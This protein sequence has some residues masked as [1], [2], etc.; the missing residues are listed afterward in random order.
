M[1]PDQA[2]FAIHDLMVRGDRATGQIDGDTFRLRPKRRR[3]SIPVTLYG[4]ILPE[5]GGTLV[6]VWPFPHWLIFLWFPIWAWFG[7]QL[8][9][10]PDWFIVL[11]FLACIA[12][13]IGETYRGYVLLRQTYGA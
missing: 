11:G 9:H 13:F 8:V 7:I 5:P 1:T 6:L 10:A 2:R 3:R 4:R 12:G